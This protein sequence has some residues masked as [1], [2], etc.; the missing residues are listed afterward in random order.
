MRTLT[1]DQAAEF[2]HIHPI[3]L[4]RMAQSGQ[5]PAVKPGKRWVFIDLD[6]A[7]WLRAQY[8]ARASEG[9]LRKERKK[10]CHSSDAKTPLFGG[11]ISPSTGNAYSALL[12]QTTSSKRKKSTTG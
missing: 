12:A 5:V 2:L 3:T 11:L 6:L 4:L 8:S 1:L 10:I 9:G 7:D